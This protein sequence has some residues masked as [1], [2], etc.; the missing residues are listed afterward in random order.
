MCYRRNTNLRDLFGSNLIMN[1]KV[2]KKKK[3]RKLNI[4][5]SGCTPCFSNTK[6]SCC[7]QVVHTKTFTSNIT[8]ETYKIFHKLNCRSKYLIYLLEC[9]QCKIQYIG[10]SETPFNIRLNNHRKDVKKPNSIPA[11]RHFNDNQHIFD[12]DAKFT[13]IEQLKDTNIE[14]ALITTRLKRRENFWINTL[15]TLHPYGLN[16]DLNEV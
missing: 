14:K 15:R 10:K 12:R 3:T 1:N 11:C 16:K 4:T 2:V 7:K 8:N 5:E 6:N 9:R 13:L